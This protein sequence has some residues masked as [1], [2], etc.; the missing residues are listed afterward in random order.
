MAGTGEPLGDPVRLRGPLQ[1]LEVHLAA[2]SVHRHDRDEAAAGD[3][4]DEQE[5]P[6]EVRH[7]PEG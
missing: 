1:V 3:E 2:L 6:L 7:R 5:P 4:A